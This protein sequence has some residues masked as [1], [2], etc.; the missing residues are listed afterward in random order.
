MLGNTQGPSNS[1]A[2]ICA[3]SRGAEPGAGGNPTSLFIENSLP[4]KNAFRT[5]C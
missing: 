5:E 4:K 1:V 2:L 3:M